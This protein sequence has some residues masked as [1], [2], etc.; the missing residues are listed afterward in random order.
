[1]KAFFVVLF[2]L[3]SHSAFASENFYQ[4]VIDQLKVA[5]GFKITLFAD[6]VENARS[7]TLAEKGVVF[8]GS[9]KAGNVYA[10]QDLDADGKADRRF[11][12]DS[13][14]YMPNGVAYY[15]GDL[16]VAETNRIIRYNNILENLNNPPEPEVVYDQLPSDRH[17]G[18]KYLRVGKDKRLYTAVGAPCNI[19]ESEQAIYTSLIRMNL[20]GSGFEMIASGIRNSVGF[21]WHPLNKKLYFTDNG[22]DHLGDDLPADELNVWT[23]SG[24]HFGYPYCHEGNLKDPALNKN[25]D[26]NA[27]EQPVWK[28]KAHMAP[29]GIRFYSG[30]Q[31]PQPY[32]NQLF[33]AQHGSWNR[34]IPQGYRVVLLKFKNQNIVSEQAFING[35]LKAD[36]EVI[37]RPVDILEL[38]DGSLLV[39]DDKLGIIYRVSYQ[40]ETE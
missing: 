19:C 1:M 11:V 23:S 16:Y 26:C 27:F 31:F 15:A 5:D 38:A 36:G 22:R 34:S 6:Q 3:S 8:I 7:M 32:Q 4:N 13:G 17:H 21:D 12:I 20:D 39:S 18:W 24:Q 9:R 2:L 33:V 37:G 10:V 14:L 25:K 28:F 30:D 29:L 35:W 40:P